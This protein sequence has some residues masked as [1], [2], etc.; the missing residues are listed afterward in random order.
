MTERKPDPREF[1]HC[2]MRKILDLAADKW[3]LYVTLTM[4]ARST[5]PAS[6]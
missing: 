3:S 5:T 4:P 1:S 2:R 6:P